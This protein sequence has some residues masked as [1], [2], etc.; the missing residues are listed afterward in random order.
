MSLFKGREELWA[1]GV[2][3]TFLG[4]YVWKKWGTGPEPLANRC[5]DSLGL[6]AVH[7]VE[8]FQR[9]YTLKDIHG[10]GEQT[11]DRHDELDMGHKAKSYLGGHALIEQLYNET[12]NDMDWD[13]TGK[14]V[15]LPC[16]KQKLLKREG[17]DPTLELLRKGAH[18]PL[19]FF[20]G[21]RG[22]RSVEAL[23][24]REVK[25]V[26]K[27]WGPNSIN[28]LKGMEQQGRTVDWDRADRSRTRSKSR[29]RS[30]RDGVPP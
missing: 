2:V 12:D 13:W 1:R 17:W 29:A 27:G 3:A 20:F 25:M 6:Y 23:E 5:F 22:R 14:G 15:Q 9:F 21:G 4:S 16:V 11:L 18:T 26:A 19:L 8:S 30:S 7:R 28:R 24:R 10:C